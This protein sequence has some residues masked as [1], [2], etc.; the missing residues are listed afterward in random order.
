MTTHESTIHTTTTRKTTGAL[1]DW[2]LEHTG[3]VEVQQLLNKFAS[4]NIQKLLDQPVAID[5]LMDNLSRST[6]AQ[7]TTT[8]T[9]T[10]EARKRCNT[11]AMLLAGEMLHQHLLTLINNRTQLGVLHRCRLVP[12][13]HKRFPR[14]RQCLMTYFIELLCPTP[15]GFLNKQRLE[16]GLVVKRHVHI[17]YIHSQVSEYLLP[18]QRFDPLLCHHQP[19]CS[20]NDTRTH[21]FN[22]RKYFE[23][24][25]RCSRIE[26]LVHLLK[27]F[28]AAG[29]FIDFTL[30]TVLGELM[31]TYADTS[32][33]QQVRNADHLQAVQAVNNDFTL[34][35]RINNVAMSSIK[36]ACLLATS[37]INPEDAFG[38]E[39]LTLSSTTSLARSNILKLKALIIPFKE[40]RGV[41]GFEI[42]NFLR[43]STLIVD[44]I[45]NEGQG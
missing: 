44:E 38:R 30:E 21:F 35:P 28:N 11:Y 16:I 10:H 5:N 24:M 26:K 14:L 41:V 29:E 43:A 31:T 17:P 33:L 23:K 12:A 32:C 36:N 18:L 39:P 45:E 15:D 3:R 27:H 1:R 8:T 6:A 40:T 9:P 7:P 20:S 42:R 4:K 13:F 25:P 34:D 19:T 22:V 37:I 2:Q